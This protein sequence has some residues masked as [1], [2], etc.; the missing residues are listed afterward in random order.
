MSEPIQMGISNSSLSTKY[1]EQGYHSV[2]AAALLI[3]GAWADRRRSLLPT[4][5]WDGSTPIPPRRA[6]GCSGR[7][8]R[9]GMAQSRSSRARTAPRAM[10]RRLPPL[11]PGKVARGSTIHSGSSSGALHGA[12][13]DRCLGSSGD[14]FHASTSV[15]GVAGGGAV[16]DASVGRLGS[17][18]FPWEKPRGRG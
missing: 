7:R 4:N 14:E 18:R 15:G 9:A 11:S 6:R 10:A 2:V 16:V 1:A 3:A 13:G 8:Q 5:P 17:E 12:R